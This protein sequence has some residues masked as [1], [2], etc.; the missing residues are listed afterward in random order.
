MWVAQ[1]EHYSDDYMVVVMVFLKVA[2]TA[3]V[4]VGHSVAR[5]VVEMV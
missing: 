5:M 1:T 2:T 4:M 3:A